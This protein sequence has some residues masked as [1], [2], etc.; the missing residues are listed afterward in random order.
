M[1]Q[2]VVAVLVATLAVG[3]LIGI[4]LESRPIPASVHVAQNSLRN[5]LE[6]TASDYEAITA[7]LQASWRDKRLPGDTVRTLIDRNNS[8]AARLR[9]FTSEIPGTGAQRSRITNSYLSFVAT[10]QGAGNI[11]SILFDDI[12]KFLSARDIVRE[13]GPGIVQRLRN[14][15]LGRVATETSDLVSDTL[16]YADEPTQPRRQNIERLLA[17]IA[18]DAAIDRNMP[19]EI[20]S[21]RSA[22]RTVIDLR[23]SIESTVDGF[24][25]AARVGASARGL[26]DAV[27]DAYEGSMARIDRARTL[28]AAYAMLLL[29]VV[30]Y[31]GF[32]L[33]QSYRQIA[34]TND[35][36]QSLNE[37]LELRV[38]E[39]TKEL[40]NA[41]TELK[42]SQVQLVQAEK[43]SSLGQLVAGISHE[44]NTPLLYLA[45]NVVL[46]EERLSQLEK[47][48]RRSISAFSMR[49]SDFPTRDKYQ[50]VFASAVGQ[51]KSE[52]LENELDAAAE[53]ATDLLS[54]CA[55]GLRDLTEM[56]QSLKDFS[57][58]DRAPVGNFDVNAGLDKTLVIARN[59]VKNKANVT[60]HYGDIPDIEC[61]P[62]QINQVFLNLI[63]NA[64]Q[65]IDEFGEIVLQTARRDEDH[66]AVSVTDNG[67]GIPGEIMD[68]IRDPFF[69]TK[70]VGTGT[71]LGLSIVE[72]IVRSHGGR[73]EI[74]SALGKGSTFTVVLPLRHTSPSESKSTDKTCADP[75]HEDGDSLAEAV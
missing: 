69:T 40:E 34:T 2:T 12:V 26:S 21:L 66:V 25:A 59:I 70:E 73:L 22:V 72:E 8:R 23:S 24:S 74:E 71:G 10:L 19:R 9:E 48:V 51:L 53:E 18:R 64:A 16:E 36:L 60:K 52:A 67:C 17:T 44:I 6:I 54:D 56:A 61:S 15:R 62:S 45:N 57:R 43:M 58:L 5:E 55:D 37:S 4:A 32:R 50:Q 41:L 14:V 75:S 46:I 38:R 13:Q 47:F 29:G 65:A 42:E 3:I 1:K 7:A 49:P 31:F 20:D 11:S 39:R 27:S 63:T 68:K 35:E 33:K 30:A 28:L